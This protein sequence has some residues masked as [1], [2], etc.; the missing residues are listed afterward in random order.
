MVSS[1]QPG[2]TVCF[3]IFVPYLIKELC[4]PLA[5]QCSQSYQI[6][7]NDRH[8]IPC[9]ERNHYTFHQTYTTSNYQPF[10][11]KPHS[12]Q[13]RPQR[14]PEMI[15]LSCFENFWLNTVYL[16]GDNV[17]EISLTCDGWQ[18]SNVDAYFAVTAHW[19]A[20]TA[21]HVWMQRSA[22]LGFTKMNTAHDGV[23]LARA[24]YRVVER[25]GI[26]HKVCVWLLVSLLNSW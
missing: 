12:A 10:Q 14:K 18:A 16:Q 9:R 2:M 19:I 7:S 23:R 20:E 17:G 21:P 26:T 5:A 15:C 24:L 25:V 11:T 22:L 3:V 13:E 6:Q 8:C 4:V 1:N